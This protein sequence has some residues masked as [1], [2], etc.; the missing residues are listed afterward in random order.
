MCSSDL[1]TV[2]SGSLTVNNN[3]TIANKGLTVSGGTVTFNGNYTQTGGP[4]TLAG[5]TVNFNGA[6]T[7]LGTNNV[8]LSGAT[9][10]FGD[11]AA[12][13]ITWSG[14]STNTFKLSAGTL[15]GLGAI[16]LNGG[17]TVFAW[18]GGAMQ[19][20][21]TLATDAFMTSNVTGTLLT[22]SRPWT[23]SGTVNLL[24]S[25]NSTLSGTGTF[26]NQG[27]GTVNVAPGPGNS[28]TISVTN[29]TNDATVN[30]NSGTL[31]LAGTEIGRAHV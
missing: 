16:N 10:N 19:G 8:L 6:T 25:A 29:F 9:V 11:N 13:T 5:G 20:T 4:L 14:G 3:V 17:P 23:N 24:A 2:N 28:T 18:S 7:N 30:V 27:K 26:T 22:L 31:A 21:G 12:D 1:T 15:D